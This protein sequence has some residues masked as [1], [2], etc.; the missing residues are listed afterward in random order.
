[1]FLAQAIDFCSQAPGAAPRELTLGMAFQTRKSRVI[2]AVPHSRAAE[3]DAVSAYL[4]E[5]APRLKLAKAFEFA[6]VPFFYGADE[7]GVLPGMDAEGIALFNSGHLR[8]PFESC[9]FECPTSDGEQLGLLV[10]QRGSSFLVH[11]FGFGAGEAPVLQMYC[12]AVGFHRS[13]VDVVGRWIEIPEGA[14]P[15]QLC[16][17]VEDPFGHFVRVVAYEAA[18]PGGRVPPHALLEMVTRE[19]SMAIYFALVLQSRK[20]GIEHVVP[21]PFANRRRVEKGLHPEPEFFRVTIEDGWA[22]GEV[23]SPEDYEARRF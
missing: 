8:L 17:E 4:R 7:R 10:E 5:M 1:M 9:W 14:S 19:A 2:C 22:P 6:N 11:E 16:F 3:W 18:Q 15:G 13:G 21:R 23:I 12:Y 20:R